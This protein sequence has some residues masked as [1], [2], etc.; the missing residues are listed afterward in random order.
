[1]LSTQLIIRLT[2]EELILGIILGV[3]YLL[4]G[5]NYH[6]IFDHLPAGWAGLLFF[7]IMC[8]LLFVNG[9]RLGYGGN[10]LIGEPTEGF[11][12]YLPQLTPHAHALNGYLKLFLYGVGIV[13]IVPNILILL[14]FAAIFFVGAIWRFK[15]E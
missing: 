12:Y 11:S 4:L 13:D 3:I 7:S 5:L 8:S 10:I 1:M 6:V 15:F 2:D 9:L 14:G